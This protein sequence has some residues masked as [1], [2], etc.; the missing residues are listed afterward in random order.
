M[1]VL[2]GAR[3]PTDSGLAV[4]S[5]LHC[6]IDSRAKL[7]GSICLRVEI[8]RCGA[9]Y[10]ND[11]VPGLSLLAPIQPS[12]VAFR[13]VNAIRRLYSVLSHQSGIPREWSGGLCRIILSV[14]VSTEWLLLGRIDRYLRSAETLCMSKTTPMR[15]DDVQFGFDKHRKRPRA[16]A[17]DPFLT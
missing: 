13:R 10:P 8:L 12:A 6:K 15:R 16:E 5:F 14:I 11:D 17:N 7:A 1:E 2:C 3:F 4:R 9:I